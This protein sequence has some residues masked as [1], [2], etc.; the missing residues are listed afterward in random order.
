MATELG[1]LKN[2]KKA[3]GRAFFQ[4]SGESSLIDLGNVVM[5]KHDA[6]IDR[7][8]LGTARKGYVQITHEEPAQIEERW[9]VKV[10]ELVT[11]A[12]KLSLLATQGADTV[13]AP[14]AAQTETFTAVKLGNVL[15]CAKVNLSAV[16]VK[17][18]ATVLVAGTDYKLD[19]GAGLV[20]LLRGSPTIADGDNITVVYDVLAATLN[21]F[22]SRTELFVPGTFSLDE[23]DVNSE[24]PRMRHSFPA[25]II[26]TDRGDNDG[27]KYN[28]TTF[29]A[30]ATGTYTCQKR[31][32]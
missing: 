7:T 23:Y 11:E 27:K 19:A 20:S 26:V 24:V 8:K 10:D 15:K 6:K 4:R 3:T 18:G 13:Q 30:L 21:N 32:D 1:D 12:V 9:S 22:T 14:A 17:K 29:E 5:H 28:E 31:V 25:E 16:Q 2:R